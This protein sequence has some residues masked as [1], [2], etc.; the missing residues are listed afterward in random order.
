MSFLQLVAIGLFFV[1]T[2]L[3]EGPYSKLINNLGSQC[4]A[5]GTHADWAGFPACI[6]Y[7]FSELL[8]G[9]QCLVPTN[10]AN[11]LSS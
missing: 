5:R 2:S 8:L 3:T 9:N 1:K 7:Y 10:F 11:E 6:F 4:N